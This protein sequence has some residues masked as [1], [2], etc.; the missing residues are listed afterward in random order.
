VCE[1]KPKANGEGD[2]CIK[3]QA[4]TRWALLASISC[5]MLM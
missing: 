1:R 3:A 4:V 5:A 2:E